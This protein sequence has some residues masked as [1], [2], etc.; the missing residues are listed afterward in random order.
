MNTRTLGLHL[1]LTKNSA[2]IFTTLASLAGKVGRKPGAAALA[3][4]MRSSPNVAEQLVGHAAQVSPYGSKAMTAGQPLADNLLNLF[5][6]KAKKDITNTPFNKMVGFSNSLD[7]RTLGKAPMSE[8]L[9]NREVLKSLPGGF[10]GDVQKAL[11]K[12]NAV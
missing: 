4:T 8:L 7:P 10:M 1:G 2:D 9:S 3:K 5:A 12:I 11:Q 6:Q